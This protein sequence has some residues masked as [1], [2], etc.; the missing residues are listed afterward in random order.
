MGG[1]SKQFDVAIVGA[2]PAGM[3]AALYASR[4]GLTC[5]VFESMGPG[6]QMTQTER[7]D[8]Y[9]GFAE[10][11]DAFELAFAMSSQAE[12]FGAHRISDEVESLQLNGVK[13]S[14]TCVS[15]DEYEARCVVLAMGAEPRELGIPGEAELRGRGVS[16]CATCDGG[17]FR[18]KTAVVVGGGNT[19][20][21]DALYLARICQKVYLVHRRDEFRADAVYTDALVGLDNVEV[22]MNAVVE[23]VHAADGDSPMPHVGSVVVR[24]KGST[25]ACTISTD[26]LFIAVGTKPKST[27]AAQGGVSLDEGGYVVAGE[28]GV[29]NIPGVFVAG[30]LRK[31]PLRQVVTA[32]ADGANAATSA[33]EYLA[34]HR[35]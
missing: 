12:R 19:A 5:A 27:L 20:V 2:G 28:D 22:L 34:T 10:G 25:A 13:K 1:R 32:V 15:G 23:A 24:Q 17:F 9:P 31:K 6:G 3:A 26:A 18:G 7:L 35:S 21:G 29:T 30:D 33:F 14:L 16:Y 8:N 4:A 11:V